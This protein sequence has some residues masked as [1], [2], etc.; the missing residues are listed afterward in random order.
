MQCNSLVRMLLVGISLYLKSVLT[1][2]FLILDTY[3]PVNL[4]LREQGCEDP[5]LFFEAKRGP[6]ANVGEKPPYTNYLTMW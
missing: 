1:Y 4:H 3:D 2:I 6:R 5:R